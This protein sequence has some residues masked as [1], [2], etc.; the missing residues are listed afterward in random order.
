MSFKD[1]WGFVPWYFKL[2]WLVT[3]LGGIAFISFVVWAI[4]RFVIHFT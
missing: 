1:A 2:L 4:Y 3:A